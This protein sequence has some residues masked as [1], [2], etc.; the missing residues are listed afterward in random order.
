MCVGGGR[1]GCLRGGGG[2]G[3]SE[4]CVCVVQNGMER[5]GSDEAVAGHGQ[6]MG[7]G[8]QWCF[9]CVPP[10]VVASGIDEKTLKVRPY[11]LSQ[12][13]APA[14]YR[15][16]VTTHCLRNTSQMHCL[17]IQHTHTRRLETDP[18]RVTITAH[19]GVAKE[20]ESRENRAGRDFESAALRW[21]DRKCWG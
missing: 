4:G 18:F 17:L 15:P 9:A 6:G 10:L 19:P 5:G 12:I 20:R 16:C 2:G 8:A 21:F 1:G 14:V 7:A 11:G 13:Q 3:G